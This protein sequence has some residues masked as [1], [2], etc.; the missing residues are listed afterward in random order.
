MF[1][2]SKEN[3]EKY[4]KHLAKLK[5]KLNG[6]CPFCLLDKLQVKVVFKNSIATIFENQFPYKDVK[7][8]LVVVGSHTAD[9][10]TLLD[11]IEVYFK[12]YKQY[13]I[14]IKPKGS[15]CHPHI[16]L[17]KVKKTDIENIKKK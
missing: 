3:E 4:K 2:R 13:N 11:F 12:K 5:K 17:L 7:S 8:H 10:T 15:V 9:Y 16:H 6:K 1:K 14:Y